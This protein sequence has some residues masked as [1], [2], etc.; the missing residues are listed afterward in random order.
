M[1]KTKKA[2]PRPFINRKVAAVF[3]AYPKRMRTRLMFLRNMI[4]EMA[5][6]TEGV[7][8]LEETLKWG[9]PS[10]LTTPTGSGTTIRIDRISSQEGKYALCVH[11]QTTL[12]GPFRKIYGDEFVYDGNRG[13]ILDE[14]DE[15]PVK[16]LNHFIY[17]A[18]TY[19]L[20]K[21]TRDRKTEKNSFPYLC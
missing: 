10:Y 18:L 19:H 3:D 13:V 14:R 9:S 12:V 6:I 8:E 4:F 21:K 7:G 15:I 5:S 20:H 2:T 17:L 1:K 16:E 11:C